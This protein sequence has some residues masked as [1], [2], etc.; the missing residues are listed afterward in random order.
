[1]RKFHSLSLAILGWISYTSPNLAQDDS[2]A[3]VEEPSKVKVVTP[4]GRPGTAPVAMSQPEVDSCIQSAGMTGQE[5]PALIRVTIDFTGTPTGVLI[6]TSSGSKDLDHLIAKCYRKARYRPAVLDGRPVSADVELLLKLDEILGPSTC[7]P[8][9]RRGGTLRI[10]VTPLPTESEPLPATGS[11]VLCMC[12][13]DGSEMEL[14][15]Q[16]PSGN[17]RFD[18]GALKLM[19]KDAAKKLWSGPPGCLAFRLEF[20]THEG[21]S[22]AEKQ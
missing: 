3:P 16:K 4:G 10:G 15:I 11:S 13:K 14:K 8:S 12:S 9:T 2:K 18:D 17:A 21:T 6:E 22:R 19:T 20:T 7:G 1:M 5:K